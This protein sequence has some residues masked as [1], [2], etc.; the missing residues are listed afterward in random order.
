MLALPKWLTDIKK[1]FATA[2]GKALCRAA[3][4]WVFQAFAALDHNHD[5][6]YADIA[7]EHTH[8][9]STTLAKIAE[10]DGDPTWDGGAWPGGGSSS[11]VPDYILQNMG[12]M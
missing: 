6:D 1:L 7:S 4:A 5:S 2:N 10:A 11:T 8:A 3:G 12:V 9:N